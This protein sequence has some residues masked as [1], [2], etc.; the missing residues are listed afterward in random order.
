MLS[1]KAFIKGL[2]IIS[3]V[4]RYDPDEETAQIWRLYLN[5]L[6]D[7]EFLKGVFL[8]GHP[9]E[10]LRDVY[11]HTNIPACVYDYIEKAKEA[12]RK[13]KPQIKEQWQIE[14]EKAIRLDYEKTKKESLQ[15]LVD[16]RPELAALIDSIGKQKLLT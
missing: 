10:G 15:R 9:K 12:E 2:K 5:P 13:S 6:N 11:P 8:L 4:F 16:R 3:A 7:E 1:D 14:R